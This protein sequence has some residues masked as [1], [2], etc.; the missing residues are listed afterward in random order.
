MLSG[1]ETAG[2]LKAQHHSGICMKSL[3]AFISQLQMLVDRQ[4]DRQK[5]NAKPVLQLPAAGPDPDPD[6]GHGPAACILTDSS[7]GRRSTMLLLVEVKIGLRCICCTF[8]SSLLSAKS[9]H[10]PSVGLPRWGPLG[11]GKCP[12]KA[13]M[14]P[15]Q[16]LC[17]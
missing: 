12:Q 2:T 13:Q 16:V 3:L 4:T 10:R 14:S 8:I 11:C 1:S 6:G 7:S 5:K 9:P 17:G 15:P